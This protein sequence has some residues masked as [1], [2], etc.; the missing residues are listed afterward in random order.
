VYNIDA[1]NIM[2][3]YLTDIQMDSLI[4]RAKEMRKGK[5]LLH[6]QRKAYTVIADGHFEFATP[7]TLRKFLSACCFPSDYRVFVNFDKGITIDLS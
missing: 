3:A 6:E 2:K 1:T 4:D 5:K 7:K